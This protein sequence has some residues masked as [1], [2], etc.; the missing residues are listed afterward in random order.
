MATTN[1]TTSTTS[2]TNRQLKAQIRDQAN[3]IDSLQRRMNTMRDDM[4]VMKSEIETFRTRVQAD[5]TTVFD[6]MKQLNEKR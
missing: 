5:M 3:T 1:P 6:G 4:A 2:R